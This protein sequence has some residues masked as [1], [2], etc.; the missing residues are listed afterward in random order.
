MKRSMH[1]ACAAMYGAGTAGAA[2]GAMGMGG[3]EGGGGGGGGDGAVQPIAEAPA[4][5]L[6]G[7]AAAA[8]ATEQPAGGD[9][10]IDTL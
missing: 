2:G 5:A 1:D 8:G 6:S 10:Q 3:V 4:L 7:S 9:G